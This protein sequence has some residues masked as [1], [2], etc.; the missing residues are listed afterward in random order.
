MFLPFLLKFFLTPFFIHLARVH[1]LLL[2]AWERGEK[3]LCSLNNC[4]TL[5]TTQLK[6]NI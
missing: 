5:V 1:T 2:V 4:E 3:L 6:I